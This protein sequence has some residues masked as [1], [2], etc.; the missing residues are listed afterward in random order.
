MLAAP[1]AFVADA[2]HRHAVVEGVG[3]E[4]LAFMCHGSTRPAQL[5]IA[6]AKLAESASG[7]ADAFS[8]GGRLRWVG[9]CRWL[10]SRKYAVRAR[11][12]ASTAHSEKQTHRQ[13][14]LPPGCVGVDQTSRSR[15]PMGCHIV[16]L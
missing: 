14:T 11:A 1:L 4:E 13:P 2:Q 8:C 3:N 10:T 6:A 9:A 7:H 15:I 5:P 16:R 12:R